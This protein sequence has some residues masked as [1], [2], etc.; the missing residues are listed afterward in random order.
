MKKQSIMWHDIWISAG[1]P[2]TGVLFNIK[3]KCKYKYKLGI[4]SAYEFYESKYSDEFVSHFLNKDMPQFWKVWNRKFRKNVSKQVIIDGYCND[5]DIANVFADNFK[6][7]YSVDLIDHDLHDLNFLEDNMNESQCNNNLCSVEEIDNAIRNLKKGKACGPDDI[8]AEHLVNAHP[9]LIIHLKLLFNM[10]FLHGFVPDDFGIGIIIPLV[11]DKAG[12]LN[13]LDN[14]R[15]ITLTPIISKVLESVVLKMYSDCFLNDDRQFGFK[16]GIGC[17]EAIFACKF[18]IDHFIQN[19]SSV[20][21]AA[22]DISKAFDRVN[23]NKLFKSL[24]KAGLP[25]G[26]LQILV[27]W[28]NKL[29]VTV[30]WNGHLSNCF[31]VSC[32][33]RQGGILSPSAFNLFIN[34]FITELRFKGVGCTV[35]G[36]YLGCILYADDIILLSSSV[37]GL[38]HM[39][40]TCFEVSVKLSMNFNCLKSQC[41]VFG[42][43]VK[44]KIQPMMLGSNFINW[45]SSIKYLGVCLLSGKSCKFDT[46]VIIRSFYCA[47]NNIF[48]HTNNTDQLLQLKLQESYCLPV[49]SYASQVI[50]VTKQQGKQLNAAWNAVYRRIFLFN[51]WESVK[52]FICGIGHL[53]FNHIV[54]LRKAKFLWKLSR[55]NNPLL[56]SI[57]HFWKFNDKSD[58]WFTSSEKQLLFLN[59]FNDISIFVLNDFANICAFQGV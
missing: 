39:L 59:N 29:F 40:N 58:C 28:Y 15:G 25:Y 20:F 4:R 50:S 13:S 57:V 31:K 26:I 33:V 14:Y 48:S 23:H 10:I 45:V 21:A 43:A 32:G 8:S 27:C 38:Q 35:G 30:R 54:M 16:P 22:L 7:V 41:I 2:M 34:L 46:D 55:S 53:D 9:S 19:G 51:R 36:I 6:K 3:T 1:K 42:T 52:S 5:A 12:D 37:S 44:Y 17:N 18:T 56:S 11:K 49:L 24:Y 47:C